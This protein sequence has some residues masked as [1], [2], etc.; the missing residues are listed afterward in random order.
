MPVFTWLSGLRSTWPWKCLEGY[1][2]SPLTPCLQLRGLLMYNFHTS[3]LPVGS[4]EGG[5]ALLG[6]PPSCAPCPTPLPSEAYRAF[7]YLQEDILP[8]GVSEGLCQ[9]LQGDSEP[10]DTSLKAKLASWLG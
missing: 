10:L 9:N 3:N 8:P 1:F 6:W 5:W 2:P 7:S 4:L